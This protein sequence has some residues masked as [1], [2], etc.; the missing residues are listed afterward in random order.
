[1]PLLQ[2]NITGNPLNNEQ[3]VELSK[4]LTHLMADELG[5]RSDLTV[6]KI[7]ES[8]KDNC[9]VDGKQLSPDQWCASLRVYITAETNTDQDISRFIDAA[10]GL[11]T[12]VMATPASA[13][14]YI[15][16]DQ[17]QS[18]CWGYDGKTQLQRKLNSQ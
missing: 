10:N 13:P 1:M 8:S 15:V 9:S 11:I 17:M 7:A 14:V 2:L 18:H 5:K 4:G 3:R 16:V 6:V 12:N